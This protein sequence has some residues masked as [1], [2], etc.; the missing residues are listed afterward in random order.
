MVELDALTKR[1]S[2]PLPMKGF[3]FRVF[4]A[5]VL[6]LLS[7]L[8]LSLSLQDWQYFERSG[9]LL[10]IV[11]IFVAWKDITGT[12][13]FVEAS[14]SDQLKEILKSAEQFEPGG[15][16]SLAK[17]EKHKSEVQNQYKEMRAMFKAFRYRLRTME[18]TSLIL[19]TFIWGYGG[20][21]GNI[22]YEFNA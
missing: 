22:I 2:N 13:N 15:L 9:S 6:L 18:A 5:S 7:G 16:L 21:I 3:E 12:V 4:I 19:G 14:M 10:V 17:N 1:L 20:L 8:C 11:G